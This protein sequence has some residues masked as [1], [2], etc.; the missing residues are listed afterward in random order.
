MKM[1]SMVAEEE[2]RTNLLDKRKLDERIGYKK[3]FDSTGE[4]FRSKEKRKRQ[5]GQQNRDG[6]WVE[7]EKRALR[8]NSANFES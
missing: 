2:A 4:D 6:N 3:R 8:H 1:L 5:L 7:E